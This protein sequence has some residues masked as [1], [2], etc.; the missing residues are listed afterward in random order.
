M[1]AY[2]QTGRAGC[3]N[4]CVQTSEVGRV[5]FRHINKYEFDLGAKSA[6]SF[7]LFSAFFKAAC[8]TWYEFFG[9]QTRSSSAGG[10][11]T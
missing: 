7:R 8:L 9:A 11:F 2:R 10:L 4:A 3:Y 1:K 5:D 6:S